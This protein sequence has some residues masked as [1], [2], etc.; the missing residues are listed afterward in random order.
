MRMQLSG[1]ASIR[2]TVAALTATLFGAK[3]A[4]AAGPLRTDASI[5]LYS[6]TDRVTTGEAAL[7]LRKPLTANYTLGLRFTYDALTGASPN[8][9]TPANKLQTFTGPSGETV[10]RVQ[11]GQFPLDPTFR[12]NRFAASADISRLLGRLTTVSLGSHLSFESDYSSVGFNAGFTRDFFQKNT[13]VGMSGSYSHDIASPSGGVPLGLSVVPPP[14][15]TGGGEDDDDEREGEGDD[16][17]RGTGIGHAGKDVVDFVIGATQV[18]NRATVLRMNYSFDHASGYQNDPY[19]VISAVQPHAGTEPG[20][21][22]EYLYE[23]RP[24]TRTKH[25]LFG[26]ALR[27]LGR[28]TLDLSYRYFWDTWGITSTTAEAS[29][30]WR[31]ARG[32]SIEPHLRWYRQSRAD[33]YH[34]FL[35][36]GD[37]APAYASADSRLADFDA[38]TIGLKYTLPAYHDS[39]I[40]LS[41]EYYFQRGDQSPPEAFGSL[42]GF[43]LFPEMNA[44]MLRVG[45]VHG[46]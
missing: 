1:H 5:L 37:T 44:F 22:V 9:A 38:Y 43:D 34:P 24:D 15:T 32:S 10:T 46:F 31:F 12:D 19:K 7:S 23:S 28:H 2:G 29:F 21:P 17:G 16:D 30:A 33:F 39:R 4:E 14:D 11:P 42:R 36:H 18:L 20:E 25:A 26:E 13:T 45:L 41:G 6:E 27:S 35:I 3:G 40:S 8:G